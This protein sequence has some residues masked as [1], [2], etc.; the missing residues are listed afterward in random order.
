MGM[1]I[2]SQFKVSPLAMSKGAGESLAKALV[3]TRR[4]VRDS[5]RDWRIVTPILLLTL[6]FPWIMSLASKVAANFAVAYGVADNAAIIGQQLVPFSLLIVGFF[7]ISFSLVIALETFVG[8]RERNTLEPLLATPI[9]DGELYLGKLLAAMLLP[10]AAS[11]LGLIFHLIGLRWMTDYHMPAQ[12]FLQVVLLTTMEALVMVAGAVVVSSHTTSVRAANLLASF[13][14]VPIA[15]FLQGEAVL[16]F[17]MRYDVIWLT[18]LGLLIVDLALVRTG[19][20]IFSREEILAR[21]YDEITLSR[22]R[23]SFSRFWSS[24]PGQRPSP[25]PSPLTLGRLYRSHLPR[26]LRHYLSP[27]SVVLV[28]MAGGLLVGW[29]FAMRY[30]LSEIGGLE[31]FVNSD[32]GREWQDLG[33]LPGLSVWGIFIHNVRA[34]LIAAFLGLISFGAAPLLLFLIP[35]G[36]VG[37]LLG[38]AASV[39]YSPFIALVAFVLPHGLVE[40]PAAWIATAFALKIGAAILAPPRGLSLGEGVL[41]AIVNFLKIFFLLVVPLL[42]LAAFLEARVTPLVALWL[43]GG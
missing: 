37:F 31:G 4:E 42:L 15:L 38:Q 24:P 21:Q 25:E 12:A 23:R 41:L 33:L 13:I 19:I 7:P 14:I 30:P 11:Y 43:L 3:I 36:M 5:L 35:L 18:I 10:V 9:S 29:A 8:E 6:I 22:L 27:L 1:E 26:L 20:R 34:L 17:W 32:L 16:L 28:V 2:P 39:G 40:I